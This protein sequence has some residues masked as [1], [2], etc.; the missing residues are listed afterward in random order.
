MT[1]GILTDEQ[2][3]TLDYQTDQLYI[4]FKRVVETRLYLDAVWN[5]GLFG[6]YEK[7]LNTALNYSAYADWDRDSPKASA[8]DKYVLIH[9]I[10]NIPSNLLKSVLQ[11]RQCGIETEAIKTDVTPN[12]LMKAVNDTNVPYYR[13]LL[14]ANS[15]ALAH[16]FSG[17]ADTLG[18]VREKYKRQRVQ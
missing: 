7:S 15:I 5:E 6:A 16:D 3:K 10:G 12:A 17:I 4:S 13:I 18:Y 14:M 9:Y 2:I 11:A 8:V 1:N